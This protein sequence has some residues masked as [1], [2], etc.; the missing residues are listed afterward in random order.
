M[1]NDLVSRSAV[2]EA[3]EAFRR[4]EPSRKIYG[5][6]LDLILDDCIIEI[7]NLPADYDVGKVVER[8]S[9]LQENAENNDLN[10]YL[11]KAAY[12]TAYFNAIKAVESGYR[13]EKQNESSI[14]DRDATELC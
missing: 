14:G 2:I 8:I 3:L 12:N 9:L 5:S 1:S 13:Q 6:V 4:N 7:N 10:A 11:E